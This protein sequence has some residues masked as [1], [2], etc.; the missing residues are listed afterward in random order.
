MDDRNRGREKSSTYIC[1]LINKKG[2]FLS[3]ANRNPLTL[4][5]QFHLDIVYYK[6]STD[7]HKHR[8]K[9]SNLYLTLC[10]IFFGVTV[11][12]LDQSLIG[13]HILQLIILHDFTPPTA[14]I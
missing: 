12:V 1:K 7:K 9:K 13:W 11:F 10:L 4:L 8:L 5:Y 2:Y 6:C 3:I 14:G